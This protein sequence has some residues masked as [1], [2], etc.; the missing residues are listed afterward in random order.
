MGGLSVGTDGSCAVTLVRWAYDGTAY[1]SAIVKATFDLGPRGELVLGA[2]DSI[3]SRDDV[4]EASRSR[5]AVVPGDLAPYVP[6]CDVVCIGTA[7]RSAH[8]RFGFADS[9]FTRFDKTLHVIDRTGSPVPVR[10]EEAAIGPQREN[11]QGS[12]SPRILDPRAPER[13]S[14]FA[15]IA[16]ASPLRTSLAAAF[17]PDDSDPDC[18]SYPRGYPFAAFQCAPLDQRVAPPRG[19]EWLFWDGFGPGGLERARVPVER[20]IVRCAVDGDPRRVD[21]SVDLVF[22]DLDRRRC[23][24]RYR[25]TF[26]VA[27]SAEVSLLAAMPRAGVAI[28]FDAMR[29]EQLLSRSGLRGG[30]APLGSRTT[31][32]V[33]PFPLATP[34]AKPSSSRDATPFGP[35]GA[36]PSPVPVMPGQGTLE[37]DTRAARSTPLPTATS[38]PP[39]P[40]PPPRRS[41]RPT[42][43]E[44]P[45]P[46]TPPPLAPPREASAP[47]PDLPPP[48]PARVEAPAPDLAARLARL[49]ASAAQ[50]DAIHRA[51][52][53]KI[54]PPASEEP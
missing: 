11:P 31:P 45:L 47:P 24:L 34:G 4:G 52:A 32:H 15:P 43:S 50:V 49:G 29:L 26:A 30:T 42:S 12:A 10:W 19:G 44:A 2:P 13:P 46:S 51:L 48:V 28:D 35:G 41:A 5:S 25:G 14:A 18:V 21:L 23:T 54:R 22:L 39:L 8:V 37:F 3:Q 53:P 38:L 7:A 17:A 20:P 27:R 36:G 1:A 40:P 6:Q 16:Q 9:A 33:T